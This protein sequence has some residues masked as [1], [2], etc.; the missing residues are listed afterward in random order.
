MLPG[1]H[2]AGNISLEMITSAPDAQQRHPEGGRLPTGANLGISPAAP[3]ARMQEGLSTRSA[4]PCLG[5]PASAAGKWPVQAGVLA[6]GL[7][8]Q[9]GGVPQ[10]DKRLLSSRSASERARLAA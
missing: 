8:R 1:K 5:K 2:T 3:L 7:V 6:P 9:P 4:L 10:V